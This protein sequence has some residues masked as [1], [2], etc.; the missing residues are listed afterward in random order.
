SLQWELIRQGRMKPEEVYMNEP[1]N[2]ITRSLG[3]EPVVKVDIEGPY[4]V[5]EGDRYILC[6]DGLT[7]HLKDEEIGMIARY[8]EPSDAC[9]LMINLANL[10]GG[11]DNISVIVVRVGELPDVNLPQEKAPEPEPELEL[12]RDYREWFWLAGV[13]V[14][15]LMVAA[16]IVMWILTRF[17]RGS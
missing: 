11:S 3:P 16:G 10:R 17:D 2:V 14:A 12:E 7:C 4:T 15:S 8:L 6:S 1:R 13:W 9:R 5:L